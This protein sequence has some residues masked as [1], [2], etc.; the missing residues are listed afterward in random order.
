MQKYSYADKTELQIKKKLCPLDVFQI[1]YF[2]NYL[3]FV[4]Q[5][6]CCQLF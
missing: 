2:V 3:C 5:A 1:N 6:K 4:P